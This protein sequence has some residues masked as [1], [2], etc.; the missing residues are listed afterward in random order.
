M[1][2][3]FEIILRIPAKT[4]VILFANVLK[5]NF[6]L[7]VLCI[8]VHSTVFVCFILSMFSLGVLSLLQCFQHVCCFDGGLG[9]LKARS[10]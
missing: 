7:I 4:I 3:S 9:V 6:I 1:I 10:I 8:C 5:R 2:V